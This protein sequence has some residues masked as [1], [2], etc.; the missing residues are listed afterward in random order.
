M[1][2]IALIML[3]SLSIYTRTFAQSADQRAIAQV[4]EDQRLAWNAGDLLGYMQ[5]YWN[6]DSLVF[7]G[8]KG[9]QYGWT[10]T[11][12]N[13]KRSYP[14]K[15][16]MGDLHFK[17]LKIDLIDAQNAFVMGEWM[18]KREKDEPKG[19]FT[20]RLKKIE[21]AWKIIVDHSS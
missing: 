12:E 8:K 11:L 18:L 9:P 15:L 4:L 16:S 13:Y 5:G 6:S 10:K 20:L 14:N 1:R 17:L 3:L 19:Y 7:I 2:K 21:G